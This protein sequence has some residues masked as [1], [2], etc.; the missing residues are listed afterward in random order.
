[1][2]TELIE[3]KDKIT[4][5]KL[6]YNSVLGELTEMNQKSIDHQAEVISLQ[7]QLTYAAQEGI[8]TASALEEAHASIVALEVEII[9]LNT[10]N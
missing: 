5:I 3:E 6:S 8:S 7:Q 9:E 2:T 10:G 4:E 1:M